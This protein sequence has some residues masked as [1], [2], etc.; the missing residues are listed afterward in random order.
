MNTVNS[1][2]TE[3]LVAIGRFNPPHKGHLELLLSL[4]HI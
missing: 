4:I 1:K 3:C 2:K